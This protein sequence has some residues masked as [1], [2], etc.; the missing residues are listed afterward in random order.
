MKSIGKRPIWITQDSATI[1]VSHLS[2]D[3]G[4]ERGMDDELTKILREI[5]KRAEVISEGRPDNE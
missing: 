4:I 1:L 2:K 3:A 5:L